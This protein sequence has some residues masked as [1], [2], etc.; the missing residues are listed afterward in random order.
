MSCWENQPEKWRLRRRLRGQI[1]RSNFFHK[2]LKQVVEPCAERNLEDSAIELAVPCFAPPIP[3]WPSRAPQFAQEVWT[4]DIWDACIPAYSRS[5]AICFR[6]EASDIV[7][8]EI[9][10]IRPVVPVYKTGTGRCGLKLYRYPGQVRD[11]SPIPEMQIGNMR[12]VRTVGGGI[13]G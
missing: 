12:L 5:G 6:D 2:G 13:F 9:I 4:E 3:S 10:V 7:I 11:G 8:N 1:W